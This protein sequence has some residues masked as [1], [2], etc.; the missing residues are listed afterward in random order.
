M[1]GKNGRNEKMKPWGKTGSTNGLMVVSAG[2]AAGK[3]ASQRGR[4][5]N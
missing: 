2:S 5:K 3:D 1:C 4:K